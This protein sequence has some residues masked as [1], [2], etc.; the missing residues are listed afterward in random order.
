MQS[1]LIEDISKLTISEVI[2]N[3]IVSKNETN[4]IFQT[5]QWFH[6]WWKVF[7]EQNRLFFISI[8]DKDKI[9]GLA[10]LM[11]STDNKKRRVLRFVGNEKAD[12]A[13]FIISGS[14]EKVLFKIFET[15]FLRCKE[16]DSI[17]LNNIPEYSLTSEIIKKICAHNNFKLLIHNG[18][19]CPT[20]IIKGHEQDAIKISNK[21]SLKRRYNYLRNSGR[22]RFFHI[23]SLHEAKHYLPIFLNQHIDRWSI[24]KY[25]SLFLD[26]RN[27][28]FYM[29][30]MTN[31]I[32]S[33][34]LSFSVVEYDDHPIAFHF[35]FQYNSKLIWYKPSFDI[36]YSKRSPGKVLIR[37]L[38]EYAINN[39]M[40]ELDFTVGDEKFKSHFA[41]EKKRNVQ[42]KIYTNSIHFYRDLVEHH[43]KRVFKKTVR[44]CK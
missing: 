5:Y 39:G 8:H 35:G 23:T 33:G 44:F 42:I 11:I 32:N 17:L 16:W 21:S 43:A 14:K 31:L 1:Y 2:W 40:D 24:T 36:N 13:D 22:L 27:K 18:V 19:V 30:L 20:L 10:P 3:Q 41:N 4:T 38:L 29:E 15:I 34:W 9:I 7:G 37:C 28:E 25:P 12:Y 26:N 6:S